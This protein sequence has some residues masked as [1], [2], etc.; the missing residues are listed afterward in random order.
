MELVRHGQIVSLTMLKNSPGCEPS[1][2]SGKATKCAGLFVTTP[3]APQILLSNMSYPFIP[4]HFI[5]PTFIGIKTM[6][7]PSCA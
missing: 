7:Q 2:S 6:S 5:V 4:R 3:G 1:C